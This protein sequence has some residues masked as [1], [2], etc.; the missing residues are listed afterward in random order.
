MASQRRYAFALS[1]G[2][3][4]ALLLGSL[5]TVSVSPISAT[6][7][8][9]EDGPVVQTAEGPV[10]GF[11]KDGVYEFLGIPYG[12]PP[13]LTSSITSQPYGFGRSLNTTI[14]VSGNQESGTKSHT[15][16]R[17]RIERRGTGLRGC[18]PIGTSASPL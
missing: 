15:Y 4:P 9:E 18:S 12:A 2:M 16:G 5:L 13:K 6:A 8:D 3:A 10:R 11:I 7:Q 1:K 17:R 14:K